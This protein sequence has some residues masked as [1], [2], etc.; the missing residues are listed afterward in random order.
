MKYAIAI[1][2]TYYQPAYGKDWPHLLRD[3]ESG[4]NEIKLFDTA[5]KA[6]GYIDDSQSDIYTTSDG[7]AGRPEMWVVSEDAVCDLEQVASDQSLYDWPD[8]CDKWDCGDGCG[9]VCGNADCKDCGP[10]LVAGDLAILERNKI[11]AKQAL[12]NKADDVLTLLLAVMWTAGWS[13]PE[14]WDDADIYAI[15]SAVEDAA[16]SADNVK[17]IIEAI[18]SV[19][20]DELKTLEQLATRVAS[21]FASAVVSRVRWSQANP[22]GIWV[23]ESGYYGIDL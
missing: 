4:E 22:D 6:Q 3:S 17:E 18:D 8:D 7:E 23:P 13:S 11:D 16:I 14:I 5:G 1:N 20:Y 15:E 19:D 10:V 12:I 9:N 2:P 21:D